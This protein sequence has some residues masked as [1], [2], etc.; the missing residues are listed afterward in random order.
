MICYIAYSAPEVEKTIA[1]ARAADD[2]ELARA[3]SRRI[4]DGVNVWRSWAE[5]HGTNAVESH[6]SAGAVEIPASS[7]D[8]VPT[9]KEKYEGTVENKAFVGVGMKLSEAAKALEYA[10]ETSTE[11]CFYTEEMEE[12]LAKLKE[13]S[14]PLLA[15][16]GVDAPVAP[17]PVEKPV[18][19]QGDHEEAANVYHLLNEDRPKPP[20]ATHAAADFEAQ[21]HD[22]AAAGEAKDQDQATGHAARLDQVKQQVVQALQALKAQA[23]ILEQ[24][25]QQAPQAYQA[26]T[27]LS[28]AVIGFARELAPTPMAKSEQSAAEEQVELV[29][30]SRVPGLKSIDTAH[31]GTGARGA[32]YR[33]G[34]PQVARAYYYRKDTAPEPIV[35]QG[36]R[37]VYRTKLDPGQRLYDLGTD[38][39]NLAGP[40]REKFL[41][42]KGLNSPADT[43]L[44]EIKGRG[45]Y[46]YHNSASSQPGTVALFYEHPVEEMNK[47]EM[48]K[49]LPMPHAAAHHHVILPPGS[50]VDDKVKVQ[51][52]D[53]GTGW[54]EAR[55]GQVRSQDPSGHPV[56]SLRPN[57]K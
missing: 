7:L 49:K 31:M 15:K 46:G 36:A 37:A 40:A 8:E 50:V 48:T 43:L 27:A 6:G 26:L 56:S 1:G 33:Q 28:Q 3:L 51:H 9:I 20:E 41:A 13:K 38:P 39:E 54:I 19:T 4:E 2:P 17:V 55:A 47:D 23:P 25:K 44:N 21:L 10:V 30:H 42:G 29:H 52:S 45:Y 5:S 11:I 24:M 34:L 32:E 53:G 14:D 57:S 35:T 12:A 16:S 22:Q 18:A